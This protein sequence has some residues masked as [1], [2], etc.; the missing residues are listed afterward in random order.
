MSGFA[1]Q[2]PILISPTYNPS[3]YDTS[4][5]TI[6]T[7]TLLVTGGAAIGGNVSV[8]K[9]TT[10]TTSMTSTTTSTHLSIGRSAT[11][12][13]RSLFN[14][15]TYYFGDS[16][17][18]NNRLVIKNTDSAGGI[19]MNANGHTMISSAINGTT[20]TTPSIAV[21]QVHGSVTNLNTG[22]GWG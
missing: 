8:G 21:L 1:S 18:V 2:T 20:L 5:S 14:F 17:S 13:N 10:L 22:A 15:Q 3:F 11:T 16:D 4:S 19:T 7:G 12:S 6:T 9:L